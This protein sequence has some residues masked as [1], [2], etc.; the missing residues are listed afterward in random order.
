MKLI[1]KPKR[2][3]LFGY[4]FPYRLAFIDGGTNRLIVVR[5][6]ENFNNWTGWLNT[7]S[8]PVVFDN[9]SD[10]TDIGID[11][12]YNILVP[13]RSKNMIHKFNK[14]GKYSCS[15]TNNSEFSIPYYVT[16][17]PDN[18]P[19][20]AMVWVDIALGSTWDDSNGIRRYLPGADL[21]SIQNTTLISTYKLSFIPTDDIHYIA[22]VIRTQDN[23]VVKS[24]TGYAFNSLQKDIIL[25]YTDLP[26]NNTNYKWKF[27][28]E[29]YYNSQLWQL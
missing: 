21:K 3:A 8:A 24:F 6:P 1:K 22:E 5:L 13:D 26:T 18:C 20:S 11:G 14:D 23:I 25:N 15:Y 9:P 12:C 10:L 28:F 29:P 19:N 16:N 4:E 7:T 27:K 17:V 2:V